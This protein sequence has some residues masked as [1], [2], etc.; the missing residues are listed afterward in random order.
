MSSTILVILGSDNVVGGGGGVEVD[1]S[2]A[3]VASHLLDELARGLQRD[4]VNSTRSLCSRNC[5]VL[6]HPACP[7]RCA[8]SK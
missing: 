4:S 7:G 2:A 1:A 8:Q 6:V 5:H 3:A